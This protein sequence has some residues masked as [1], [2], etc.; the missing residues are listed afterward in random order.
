MKSSN[1]LVF[2]NHNDGSE[3]WQDLMCKKSDFMGRPHLCNRFHTGFQR[4]RHV[5]WS[6]LHL[7]TNATFLCPMI[8]YLRNQLTGFCS[9]SLPLLFL[10]QNSQV[11]LEGGKNFVWERFE[12]RPHSFV[13]RRYD[14]YHIV[15]GEYEDKLSASP[16]ACDAPRFCFVDHGVMLPEKEAVW[17]CV[18]GSA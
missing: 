1:P 18:W 4:K 13:V 12:Q 14:S 5:C 16:S 11:C 17:V 15:P 8:F 3:N 2:I 10:K 9:F 7:S 6:G